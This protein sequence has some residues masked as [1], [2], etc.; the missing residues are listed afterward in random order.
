M[1]EKVI[2]SAKANK[3]AGLVKKTA[4]VPLFSVSQFCEAAGLSPVHCDI[5]GNRTIM[6]LTQNTLQSY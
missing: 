6:I 2:F 4:V 5:T 1:P 3:K